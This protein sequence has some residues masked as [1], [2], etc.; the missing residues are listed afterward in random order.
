MPGIHGAEEET[1]P[2][3]VAKGWDGGIHL[4]LREQTTMRQGIGTIWMCLGLATLTGCAH[5]GSGNEAA[6]GE[7]LVHTIDWAIA[8]DSKTG[9]GCPPRPPT[10]GVT[11]R[12]HV[13]H[14]ST[15]GMLPVAYAEILLRDKG[16]VVARTAS[17]RRGDFQFKNKLATGSYELVLGPGRYQGAAEVLV[18]GGTPEVVVFAT[19]LPSPRP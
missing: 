3:G 1:I 12:G 19:P 5:T 13:V 11:L 8:C 18:E 14:N 10:V 6:V 9:N 2:R 4:A 7:A 17:D 15:T 16:Q